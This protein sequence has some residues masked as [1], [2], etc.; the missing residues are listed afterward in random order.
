MSN[1]TPKKV[2]ILPP[3]TEIIPNIFLFSLPEKQKLNNRNYSTLEIT[4]SDLTL[5]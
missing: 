5:H 2:V 3:R 4:A 1:S